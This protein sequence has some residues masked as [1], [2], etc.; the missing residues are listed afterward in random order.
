[1]KRSKDPLVEIEPSYQEVVQLWEL[2]LTV[3]WL[4]PHTSHAESTGLI[5]GWVTKIP[6]D[7][8]CGQK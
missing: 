5:P 6:Y 7:M 2:P 4:R 1:M 3:Q 8:W